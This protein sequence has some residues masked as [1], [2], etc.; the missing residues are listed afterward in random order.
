MSGSKPALQP[1][2]IQKCFD[3][4]R[5][6]FSYKAIADEFNLERSTVEK[7]FRRYKF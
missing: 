2:E 3:L 7:Y 6:G 1:D 5:E 4:K